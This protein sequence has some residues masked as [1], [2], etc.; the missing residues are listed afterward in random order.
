[1][2]EIKE[3]LV[4]GLKYWFENE[5]G[6][7][8]GVVIGISGGK[9]STVVAKLFCEAIGK[10]KVLGVL[11]P[12]G[13]QKDLQIAKEVCEYL[14]ISY[15]IFDI[16]G[17]YQDIV[18]TAQ[19]DDLIFVPEDIRVGNKE[20]ETLRLTKE[21][22]IN[23]APRIRMTYLY[24][25]GQSIGYRIAG[26]TNMTENLLGYFTKYGDGAADV[27]PLLQLTCTDVIN[28]GVE[29]GLPEHFTHKVPEDGLTGKTDEEIFGYSY[30]DIDV[31]INVM[32]MDDSFGDKD[33][34]VNT[35]IDST[36]YTEEFANKIYDFIE[37]KINK[38]LHKLL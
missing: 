18:E 26:T 15:M 20:F 25:I 27:E 8:K 10:D 32:N 23:I 12:N 3:A 4:E 38:A 29:L 7:A 21:S 28:L 34:T 16:S 17:A 13:H 14:D 11:M 30:K 2:K 35:Y 6:N 37:E 22:L 24:A 33:W 1:M 36:G 31:M 19:L 5:A 9:D